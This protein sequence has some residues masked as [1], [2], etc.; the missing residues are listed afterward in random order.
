MPES[1]WQDASF[2]VSGQDVKEEKKSGEIQDTPTQSPS[3][4]AF[5]KEQFISW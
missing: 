5:G 1:E 4:V 2:G 3:H